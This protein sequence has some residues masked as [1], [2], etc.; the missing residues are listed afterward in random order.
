M[1]HSIDGAFILVSHRTMS[2]RSDLHLPP[3]DIKRICERLADGA[4][5]GTAE[6]LARDRRVVGWCDDPPQK[7]VCGK[8]AP[9]IRRD[10]GRGR[11]YPSVETADAAFL[12][13]D[14]KSHLPHPRRL[15]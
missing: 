13:H 5:E 8:V 12:P 15:L 9:Y 7:L 2:H 4:S 6:E 10:A 14:F 11:H 3:Q 1:P